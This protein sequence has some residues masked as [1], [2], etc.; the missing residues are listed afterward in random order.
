MICGDKK[1]AQECY[2]ATVKEFERTEE[3]FEEQSKTP[4]LEL[5]GEFELFNFLS[6]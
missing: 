3:E 2:F 4:K 5:D 1:A 6:A